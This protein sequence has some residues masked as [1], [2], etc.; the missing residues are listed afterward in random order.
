MIKSSDFGQAETTEVRVI[1]I[2]QPKQVPDQLSEDGAQLKH[3]ILVCLNL[4]ET[5]TNHVDYR[6]N[7]V[8]SSSLLQTESFGDDL[9]LFSANVVAD[10]KL[11]IENVLHS[12][13]EIIE[14]LA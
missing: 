11:R 3:Y 12:N 14:Q 2:D 5:Q 9:G 7:E 4:I 8:P 10:Q 6:K 1:L 13:K